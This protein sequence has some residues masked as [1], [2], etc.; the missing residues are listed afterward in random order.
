V[1]TDAAQAPVGTRLRVHLSQGHLACR[2][3][4]VVDA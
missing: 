4:E 3:E 1:I 2:V